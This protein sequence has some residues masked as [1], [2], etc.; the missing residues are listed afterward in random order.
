MEKTTIFIPSGHKSRRV[1]D[2]WNEEFLIN[3]ECD[4][5]GH[6][7]YPADYEVERQADICCVKGEHV[8]FISFNPHIVSFDI[9]EEI[10]RIL[11]H[12]VFEK[13]TK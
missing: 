13:V 3:I 10:E 4:E 2:L 1:L 5:H 6:N 11:S 8:V 9:E 12:A 7:N